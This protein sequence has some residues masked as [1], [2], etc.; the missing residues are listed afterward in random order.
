MGR[1]LSSWCPSAAPPSGPLAFNPP[2]SERAPDLGIFPRVA[3]PL[4]IVAPLAVTMVTIPGP[5]FLKPKV[6]VGVREV[7]ACVCEW[8]SETV[9]VSALVVAVRLEGI[10]CFFASS[11]LL[12]PASEGERWRPLARG[13]RRPFSDTLTSSVLPAE[14]TEHHQKVCGCCHYRMH[15]KRVQ[16]RKDGSIS[17]WEEEEEV[18]M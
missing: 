6:L 18:K 5:C 8:G 12:R 13:E 2:A 15:L 11:L 1:K 4:V 9:C 17:D 16:K 14:H 7:S 3:E 10:D